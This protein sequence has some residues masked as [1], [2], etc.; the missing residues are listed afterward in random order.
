MSNDYV[1]QSGDTLSSIARRHGCSVSTLVH[2][3][4]TLT[5]RAD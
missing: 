2:A 5:T 1:V 3:D 4:R